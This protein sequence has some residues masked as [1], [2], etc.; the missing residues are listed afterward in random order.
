MLDA[1]RHGRF[2]MDKMTALTTAMKR[3]V[4]VELAI[5]EQFLFS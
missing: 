2:V 4:R 1:F 3:I 5:R